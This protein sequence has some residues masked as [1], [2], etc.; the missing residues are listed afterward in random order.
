M[1]R[2][3]R[4]GRVSLDLLL[5]VVLFTV[6]CLVLSGL[7]D[8]SLDGQLGSDEPEWIAASILHWDQLVSGA[9]PAGADLR[10]GEPGVSP[11]TIGFQ[12]TTFGYMNP[13]LPKLIWGGTLSAAGHSEASIF[14]FQSFRSSAPDGG[15]A[16][17]L[18][19]LE[20][21]PLTRRVV[22]LL[23]ALSGVLIF[24]IGR[25]TLQGRAGCIVGALAGALWLASPLVLETASTIRTD[26]F[27][28]PWCLGLWLYATTRTELFS[29]ARGGP[30]LVRG[31][32]IAGV[33]GGL[34]VSSKL[35]GAL[36][37]VAFGLW[38][39]LVWWLHRADP[40]S[41][42]EVPRASARDLG[43]GLLLAALTAF[44][45]FVA[46]NPLLWSGPLDGVAEILR[47]WDKLMSYFQNEWAPRTGVEVA[48]SLPER[49]GLFVRRTLERDEPIRAL[50]GIPGGFVLLLGT[51][52]LMTQALRRSVFKGTAPSSRDRAL[53]ALCFC[54]VFLAGTAAWLPLDWARLYLPAAPALVLIEAALAG[55]FV[56]RALARRERTHA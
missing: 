4:E 19:L 18:Q 15:R 46:L 36:A 49:I 41:P 37:P 13:C 26:Y 7:R 51:A 11:W 14:A 56:Q 3:A 53:A 20:A 22:L 35:N 52:A 39:P 25:A 6:S 33:L 50:T 29:G 54:A 47:R 34:A 38:T 23:A 32:L 42:G 55:W 8:R 9:P 17:H 5:A 27:M 10:P 40:E 31:C 43:L 44:A 16:A 1:K 21:E 2:T 30:A 45:I 48:H 12:R 24:F 28:L